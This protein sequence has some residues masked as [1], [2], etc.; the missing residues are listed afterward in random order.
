MVIGNL[1]NI[2]I[3][4]KY[5]MYAIIILVVILC[6][7]IVIK[8][9][10]KNYNYRKAYKDNEKKKS[11]EKDKLRR[12]NISAKDKQFVL[13]RD[14]YTCQICGISKQFFNDLCPG[15]GDYLLLEI[16]HIV[17]VANG[18]KGNDVSNL[19]CLCWRCNRKKGGYKTNKDIS[20]AINYGIKYLNKSK[21]KIF[22]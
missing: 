13:E 22:K 4:S 21:R 3:S 10:I 6:L 2:M 7:Y 1:I 19:Q 14:N 9:Y 18:G 12:R 8:I 11:K 20:N 5:K 17:S 16:D 15:S